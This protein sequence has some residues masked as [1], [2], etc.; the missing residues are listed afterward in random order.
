MLDLS[1][2]EPREAVY[3]AILA[4]EAGEKVYLPIRSVGYV[5]DP[6]GLSDLRG[7]ERPIGDS[8][9]ILQGA[10]AGGLD[11][12]LKIEVRGTD[13]GDV[14]AF[15]PDRARAHADVYRRA[16]GGYV[17]PDPETGDVHRAQPLVNPRDVLR[18]ATVMR[19][20]ADWAEWLASEPDAD[21]AE[22]M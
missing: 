1:G 7:F 8:E 10:S 18:L 22:V 4:F 9:V 17:D 2:V 19:A 15:S 12:R 21:A 13:T 14:E 5:P 20:W 3:R 16:W 11:P 6:D